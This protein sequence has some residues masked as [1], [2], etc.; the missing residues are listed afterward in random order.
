ME[1]KNTYLHFSCKSLFIGKMDFTHLNN[2][3]QILY[4]ILKNILYIN[5][6]NIIDGMD[7]KNQ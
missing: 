4:N 6:W 1:A 7:A 3:S 2:I 5:L